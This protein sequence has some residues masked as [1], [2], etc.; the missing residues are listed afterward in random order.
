MATVLCHSSVLLKMRKENDFNVF[1]IY[2]WERTQPTYTSF[3]F[4]PVKYSSYNSRI[5]AL[6]LYLLEFLASYKS[7]V[8]FDTLFLSRT[9]SQEDFEDHFLR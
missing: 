6:W 1:K 5:T 9:L 8:S 2:W 7:L 3:L 4:F